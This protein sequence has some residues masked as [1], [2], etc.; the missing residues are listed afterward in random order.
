MPTGAAEGRG[1]FF[2]VAFVFRRIACKKGKEQYAC[3]VGWAQ[4]EKKGSFPEVLS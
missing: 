3:N 4:G 2:L 1:V